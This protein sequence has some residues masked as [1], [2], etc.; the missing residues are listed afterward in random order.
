[1][2]LTRR[3]LLALGGLAAS[4]LF[5][6]Q[7]RAVLR[8]FLF[9][10]GGEVVPPRPVPPAAVGAKRRVAIVRA[11]GVAAGVREAVALVDG[12]AAL[13]CRGRQVLVK[14]NVVSGRPPPAT[15]D[16]RVVAALLALL[17]ETGASRLSMGDMSAVVSLPTRPN[18]EATGM[19]AVAAAAGADLLA[20]EEGDWVEVRPPR[21]RHATAFHV[22]RAVYEAERLVSVPVLKAHRSASYSFALKNTVGVVHAR[23]K[24]WAYGGSAWEEVVAE[25]NLAVHP[26]LYVADA[27]TVMASG[28]PWSGDVVRPGCIL[29]GTDPVALDAVGLGILKHYGKADHV[30]G[31]GVWDQGQIRRAIA[32]GLGV[33]SGVEVEIVA[34]DLTAGDPAF[35]PLLD[36]VRAE[37]GAA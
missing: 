35:A 14:P 6:P 17:R 34:R 20:L 11:D 4:A 23:N 15:T 26:R 32:L 7:C 8:Q 22:A 18:L 25:L 19:A 9:S 29:A 13:D 27:L 21:A 5:F 16:P 2:R 28:G 3:H 1:M 10:P 33:Q 36:R 30:V 31:K 24:P 37:V 12:L